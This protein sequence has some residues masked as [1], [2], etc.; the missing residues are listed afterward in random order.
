MNIKLKRE[1]V[2]SILDIGGG[3]ECVIGRLYGPAVVAIDQSQE[4]L[5]EAPNCCRKL[6]MDAANLMFAPGTFDNVTFFYS[7][8]FMAEETQRKALKEA[9]RVLTPGGKLYLWDVEIPSAASYPFLAELDIDLAGTKLHT[10]YGIS[11][12]DP[13]SGLS[14]RQIAE[15]VGFEAINSSL[16]QGHFYL[17]FRK[18]Q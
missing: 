16:H 13:Q 12:D 11:K 1:I 14:I 10:T 3:G 5:D 18:K 7:L 15:K 4:E 9:F 2:G 6:R 8:M 17:C